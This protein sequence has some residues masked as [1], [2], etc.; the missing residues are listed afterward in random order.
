MAR[1]PTAIEFSEPA[2]IA[3]MIEALEDLRARYGPDAQVRTRNYIEFN[4]AG[5]R[6]SAITAEPVTDTK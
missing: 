1:K 3:E 2:T 4:A 6:V 5:G